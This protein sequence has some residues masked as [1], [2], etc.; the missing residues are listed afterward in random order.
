MSYERLATLEELLM[1]CRAHRA[2]LVDVI[3]QDE[4]THDTLV[5]RADDSYLCFDTT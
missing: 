1:W 2:E 4:Y 3:V 5:R